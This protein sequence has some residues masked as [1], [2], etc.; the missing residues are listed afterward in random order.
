[1]LVRKKRDGSVNL[2]NYGMGDKLAEACEQ[3]PYTDIIAI[4]GSSG[5]IWTYLIPL[6]LTR[7]WNFLQAF[8]RSLHSD[9]L[10]VTRLNLSG[11][12][13]HEAS[14]A[15]IMKAI[16]ELHLTAFQQRFNSILTTI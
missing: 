13:L 3:L 10:G 12:G 5:Y 11:N 7:G 16:F 15:A 4:D 1:V 14:L 9:L 6:W 2:R 8:A